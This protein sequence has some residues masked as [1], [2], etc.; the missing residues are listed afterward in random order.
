MATNS[1]ELMWGPGFIGF[2]IATVFYGVGFGQCIYYMRYFPQDS[3]KLKL[4]ILMLFGNDTPIHID[5]VILVYPCLVS[6]KHVP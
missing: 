3:R 5:R 6:S 4:F 1:A 2:M